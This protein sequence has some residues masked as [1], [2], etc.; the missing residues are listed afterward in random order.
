MASD[1]PFV[2]DVASTWSTPAASGSGRCWSCWPPSSATRP[3]GVVPAAVR[4]RA[5]PP[6]HALPRRRDG[7]GPA[8]P[9]SAVGQRPLGQHGRHPHRRLPVRPGLGDPRRPRPGGGPHPG[10]R[11]SRG[12]SPG[13][14]ARRSGRGGR[15]PARALPARG[16]RQD[17]LAD[18]DLGPLRRDVLGRRRRHDPGAH[19]FGER[20]G[21]AFQL[22]DDLL[23]VLSDSTESG[24][25]PGT[26][27]REGVPT[28]PVLHVLRASPTR[29]RPAPRAPVGAADRRRPA[30][31]GARAAA[32][33]PGDGAGPGR[34]AALGR[35]GPSPARPAPRR[36]G[37]AA[38]WRPC[39]TW[40]W[41]ARADRVD[42]VRSGRPPGC[43]PRAGRCGFRRC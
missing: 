11:P 33:A 18:R 21:V 39:A 16:R 36:P 26:D 28:L 8:A 37:E 22:S 31:R 35:R 10:R 6:R 14:S 15:R 4:R 24:K 3:P 40:S 5:D 42:R 9:R 19:G 29:G 34:P 2:A 41:T 32:G 43:R 7:R 25:T 20:I 30:R 13:R 27:L 12:W 17:R 23:D 38:L 1:D